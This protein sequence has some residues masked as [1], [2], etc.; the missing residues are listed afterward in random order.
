MLS[1]LAFISL[2]AL[3]SNGGAIQL[4]TGERITPST[5]GNQPIVETVSPATEKQ[6][7]VSFS[8]IQAS[9]AID[10]P[11]EYLSSGPI[12]RTF[13]VMPDDVQVLR[14]IARLRGRELS[15]SQ[16][17]Y[18]LFR[19]SLD[20]LSSPEGDRVQQTM[21][22]LGR[23]QRQNPSQFAAL[24]NG[25]AELSRLDAEGQ[26]LLGAF[27]VGSPRAEAGLA[28]GTPVTVQ[29]GMF[30]RLF[31]NG[32]ADSS[33]KLAYATH[34]AVT[35]LSK[36]TSQVKTVPIPFARASDGT[37]DFGQ[38]KIL[39]VA[40]L[41]SE[42]GAQFGFAYVAEPAFAQKLVFLKG[43]F[44]RSRMI[45][46]LRLIGSGGPRLLIRDWM[47]RDQMIE[48][49]RKLIRGSLA[50]LEGLNDDR[51][52]YLKHIVDNPGDLDPSELGKYGYRERDLQEATTVKIAF[53]I[54]MSSDIHEYHDPRTGD[55]RML[56][57]GCQIVLN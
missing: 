55:R 45:E 18:V 39:M 25:G 40:D 35:G 16:G 53:E 6:I 46:A 41:A 4:P 27:W 57:E 5:Y 30:P 21:A 13:P 52:A 26:S 3:Q 19:P 56:P 48:L 44:T 51:I 1:L 10:L 23:L 34:V 11:D 47:N 14:C 42:A 32:I 37:L 15:L 29:L 33:A 43:K 38:G 36:A 28:A 50:A 24:I 9:L 49:K 7:I 17:G 22:W 20:T 8:K 31:K 12:H 54:S 2:K